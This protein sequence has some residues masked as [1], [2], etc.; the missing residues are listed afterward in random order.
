MALTGLLLCWVVHRAGLRG[1][2]K[3]LAG[4]R[5]WP[6]LLDALAALLFAA[7]PLIIFLSA[8]NPP[9]RHPR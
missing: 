8:H 4:V 7:L 5:A 3:D 9:E 2:L 6:I 1:I